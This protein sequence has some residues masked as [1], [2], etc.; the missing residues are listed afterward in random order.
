MF[1][2]DNIPDDKSTVKNDINYEFC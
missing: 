2:N 1:A